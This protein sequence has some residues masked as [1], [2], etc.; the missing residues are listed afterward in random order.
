MLKSKTARL[1]LLVAVFFLLTLL[2]G[3]ESSSHQH[4]KTYRAHFKS[5]DG[6][7]LASFDLEVAKSESERELGLMYRSKLLE[8]EGMIFVYPSEEPRSFWMKNTLIPLDILF[9]SKDFKVIA[10]AQDA[11]PL[12]LNARTSDGK[13]AQ[14]VVEIQGGLANKRAIR[15]GSILEALDPLPSGDQGI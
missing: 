9:L 12:T 15:I 5:A 2:V 4:G 7:E 10:I 8:D 3:C 1:S 14:Y 11:T 6:S 13:G